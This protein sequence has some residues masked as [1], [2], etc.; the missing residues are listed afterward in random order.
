MTYVGVQIPRFA[1]PGVPDAE[2]FETAATIAATA[3]AAGAD[4][5]WVMD[6]FEQLPML[7]GIDE[8][9]LEGYV[10]LGALA[11]RTS[12]VDLGT[13]VTGITYRN[14]ALLAKMVT[15]LD[16][17]SGGRAICGVGAA[18]FDVEH[19]A[20]GFEYPSDRE[21]LDRLEEA[22]EIL[23]QMFTSD[24]PSS[25]DGRYYRTREARNLPHPLRQ[26]GPPIM[27]G[28]GG[29]KRTLRMVA[30]RADMSNVNGDPETLRRKLEVLQK[31]CGDVGRDPAEIVKTRLATVVTARTQE[32]AEEK[33]DRIVAP[34]GLGREGFAGF[35][36]YGAPDAL[37]EQAAEHLAWG[38]DGF[39][40]NLLDA[41]DLEPVDLVVRALKAAG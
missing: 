15:T 40:V 36:I 39:V 8:P 12:R 35:G 2:M 19:E 4:S 33:V 38:F 41:H 9:I 22:L 24:A 13:M 17:I 14:P 7:G 5:V 10:T 20:Y 3:E 30:E 26:G 29:E 11:T 18:W 37:T 28:G 32:Q 21:R 27:V 31:H 23:R 6:H 1:Y 25:F 34:F 16:V